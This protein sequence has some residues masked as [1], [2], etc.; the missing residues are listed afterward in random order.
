MPIRD[1]PIGRCA[2]PGRHA[3][4]GARYELVCVLTNNLNIALVIYKRAS[5][6]DITFSGFDRL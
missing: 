6:G 4:S 2:V 5:K 1:I 3:R